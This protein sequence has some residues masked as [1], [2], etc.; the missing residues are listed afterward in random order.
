[1]IPIPH[2]KQGYR[3]ADGTKV[4]GVTTIL[5]RFKESGALLFWACEQGKAIER[6]EI[7]NLYDKR[8]AAAESGTLAHS[9]VEAHIN[10]LPLPVI[11][12]SNVGKQALQGYENYVRWQEDNRIEVKKQE[13]EM[14]S[15]T[16][17][18]GGCP[19]ALGIDSRGNLCIMDWKT[20]GAIYVDYILQISAYRIL[21]EENHPDQPITGGYH[22]LRFAKE[23]ADFHHHYWNELEEAK[24]MFVL[25]VRAYELDRRLKKRV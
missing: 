13:M 9:L 15:E 1:M 2:P 18:F 17:R 4:S 7:S 6:G 10:G 12:D 11:P 16:Y 20:S 22:L 19:D 25:L 23:N 3:L 5:G 8:D 21:W 14:V 24:E